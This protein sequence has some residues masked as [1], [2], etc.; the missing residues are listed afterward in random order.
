MSIRKAPLSGCMGLVI[1]LLWAPDA[2]SRR[3]H[4]AFETLV[5]PS[6]QVVATKRPCGSWQL[7]RRPCATAPSVSR[8]SSKETSPDK[9]ER[10]ARHV[11]QATRNFGTSRIPRWRPRRQAGLVVRATEQAAVGL[12]LVEALPSNHQCI[13]QSPGGS[14]FYDRVCMLVICDPQARG[15]YP[16]V[17]NRYQVRARCG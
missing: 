17:R 13:C 11:R 7:I 8:G 15:A 14:L 12:V 1:S 9:E 4:P 6:A 3:F 16:G 10:D 2:L 5:G